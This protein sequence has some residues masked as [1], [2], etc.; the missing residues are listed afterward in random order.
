ML[1]YNCLKKFLDIHVFIV[2]VETVEN[3]II[4]LIGLVIG[5]LF[6]K[7]KYLI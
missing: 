2:E 7:S 6:L 4:F 5:Y 1:E 3:P